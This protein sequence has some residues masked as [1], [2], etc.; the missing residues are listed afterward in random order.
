VAE[1]GAG[2]AK[3]G[4]GLVAGGGGERLRDRDIRL[5]LG[6]FG[7]PQVAQS[8]QGSLGGGVSPRSSE[9]HGIQ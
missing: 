9:V 1:D 2:A 7:G 3:R 8:G 5:V 4:V 6:V